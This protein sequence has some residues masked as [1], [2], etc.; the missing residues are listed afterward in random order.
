MSTDI[1][2]YY[3]ITPNPHS[4]KFIVTKQIADESVNFDNP[5]TSGRSPL[6]QKI[7]GFPWAEGVFIGPNFV[8][9][10]K[11]DWVE[12]EILAEPL[13]QLIKEHIEREEPVLNEVTSDDVDVD[14]NDTPVVKQIKQIL[15]AEIR[16]A[17]AMDGGDI[18]FHKYENNVLHIHMQGAC[19]GCPSSTITLKQGIEARLQQAI[20]EIKEVVAVM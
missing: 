9:I 7:F 19:A 13:S 8:T 5:A 1:Q 17:V 12:W 14:E 4:M 16:P 10:T 11:Q 18:R 3:E 15:N 20:P 6:A 2:V